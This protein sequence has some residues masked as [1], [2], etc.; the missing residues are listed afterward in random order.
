VAGGEKSGGPAGGGV[1]FHQAGVSTRAAFH[2]HMAIAATD[3]VD[4]LGAGVSG[5]RRQLPT[6]GVHHADGAIRLDQDGHI[7]S[8]FP[9]AGSGGSHLEDLPD[10]RQKA[11]HISHIDHAEHFFEIPCLLR[12]RTDMVFEGN[13]MWNDVYLE[14]RVLSADP[15]ELI[16]ILYEGGLGAVEQARRHLVEGNIAARSAAISKAVAILGELNSSLN[17]A[18]GGEI[19]RSLAALYDYMQRRLLEGNFQQAD[20]PLAEVCT[21]LRTIVEG[22]SGIKGQLEPVTPAPEPIA[23]PWVGGFGEEPAASYAGQGWS[24]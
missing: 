18:Q 1:G 24:F 16:S 6:G 23:T 22:W 4:G 21:L 12:F 13:R 14:S 5:Q 3:A 9:G 17:H 19:S 15:I 10:I 20:E 2:A 7:R 11:A 8:R